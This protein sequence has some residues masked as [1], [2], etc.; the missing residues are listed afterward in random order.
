MRDRSG[1]GRK[2]DAIVVGGGLA[3][4]GAARTLAR[5]GLRHVLVL[6]RY[7]VG[8]GASS[9]GTGS[10]HV[11]RWT[12][13][14]V[15]LIQ[16]SQALMADIAQQVG[17]AFRF[18]AV[19]RMTMVGNADVDRLHELAAMIQG[20][21]GD[22]EFLSAQA[23]ASR[24]P[25]I[26]T[27]DVG[28]ATYTRSDGCVYPGALTWALAGIVRD[29]GVLVLEG[30][31]A[32]AIRLD[33]QG[34]VKGV[35]IGFPE[36]ELFE[37]SLVVVAA[38]AWSGMLLAR[39]GLALPLRQIG[40]NAIAVM[41]DAQAGCDAV[42]SFLDA[43]QGGFSYIPRNPRTLIVAGGAS[44]TAMPPGG[45]LGAA[46]PPPLTES[47]GRKVYDQLYHCILHR[48]PGWDVGPVLG[49]WHGMIDATPD[50]KPLAGPYPG[51]SGL[52]IASG[53]S[54][55]GVM[56]GMALG[57]AVAERALD[58]APSV[59]V[60]GYGLDR[61]ETLGARFDVDWHAYNPFSSVE[62]A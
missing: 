2:W 46:T 33:D 5:L 51:T 30:A 49:S 44:D 21:G 38:G 56:R 7:V 20:C 50:G 15:R 35:E 3:G 37:A 60:S 54:G 29:A 39:S 19:G 24:Y 57:E 12:E 16:R 4:L 53:L 9:R 34:H 18:N 22:V 40:A 36:P 11:Q 6:E 10:V 59:N 14:D 23:L 25:G 45:E 62:A 8:G 1:S 28:L 17:P 55:Y 32:G 47:E 61:F 41:A 42:P 52:H 27:A 43:V 31:D 13:T 26:N 48:F 58:R